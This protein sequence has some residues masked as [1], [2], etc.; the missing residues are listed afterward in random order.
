MS[1]RKLAV[2]FALVLVALGCGGGPETRQEQEA[3]VSQARATIQTMTARDP[4]LQQVL[5]RAYGYVVFPQ[6]GE[7]GFIVGGARGTN[8]VVFERGRPVGFATL[9]NISVGAQAGG[10]SFS[11]IVV[12]QTPEAFQRLR[13]GRFDLTAGVE[14]TLLS[15]GAAAQTD[16][17]EGTAVF[18]LP[19]GGLMAGVSVAGQQITFEPM[20]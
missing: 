11:E 20:V 9:S 4:S 6:V 17:S 10:Q 12:F 1:I 19:E 16:F 5:D 3:A 15:A 2:P 7:G 13:E 18:V 8:G 14:A